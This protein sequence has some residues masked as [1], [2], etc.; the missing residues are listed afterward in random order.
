MKGRSSTGASVRADRAPPKTAGRSTSSCAS[1]PSQAIRRCRGSIPVGEAPCPR[2]TS[3]RT[4][5][6]RPCSLRG[7]GCQRAETFEFE[8]RDCNRH[9]RE[10]AALQA[11]CEHVVH[12]VNAIV[13]AAQELSLVTIRPVVDLHVRREVLVTLARPGHGAARTRPITACSTNGCTSRR[14]CARSTPTSA[15]CAGIRPQGHQRRGIPGEADAA[16]RQEADDRQEIQREGD[17]LRAMPHGLT[18]CRVGLE[19]IDKR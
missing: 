10:F 18:E 2:C 15:R 6:S 19:S 16:S 5:S 8:R 3:G 13:H 4:S 1:A 17:A 11:L 14:R 9:L 7:A 12:R